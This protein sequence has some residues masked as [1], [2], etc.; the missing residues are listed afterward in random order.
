MIFWILLFILVILVSFVLALASM[1]EFHEI[2]RLSEK[3]YGLFLIRKTK[4]LTAPFLDELN[5]QILKDALILSFERLFKGSK[6]S[7]TMFAPR[8]ITQTYWRE[9]D[10]V[11]IEDY[12][13]CDESLILGFEMGSKDHLKNERNFDNFFQSFPKLAD[14]ESLWWQ[15]ITRAKKDGL[16]EVLPRV[17]ILSKDS[18]K[19]VE[20]GEKLQHLSGG[21]LA[22]IPKPY[23]S[24]QIL[25]FYRQ[26]NLGKSIHNPTLLSEEVLKL[27][28]LK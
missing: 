1:R 9:L 6:S 3:D 12:T 10:L 28:L 17:I 2:P 20:L 15:L 24:S 27:I 7:L 25:K 21:F 8:K 19:R 4:S 11:E 22:K 5:R 13:T 14:D 18:T 26:R 23:T 16:F